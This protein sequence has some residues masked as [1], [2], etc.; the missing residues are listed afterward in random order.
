VVARSLGT[1]SVLWTQRLTGTD[2]GQRP[3][4]F[5]AED[6][7]VFVAMGGTLHVLD[8]KTGAP[9]PSIVSF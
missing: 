8:A 9:K 6:G 1:G 3:Q 5:A 4:D 7:R 2:E